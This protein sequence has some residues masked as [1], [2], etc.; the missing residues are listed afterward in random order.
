MVVVVVLLLLLLLLCC[1]PP[2]H[3]DGATRRPFYLAF[4]IPTANLLFV[5]LSLF[6]GLCLANTTTKRTHAA[7]QRARQGWAGTGRDAVFVCAALCSR[8]VV[9]FAPLAT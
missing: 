7:R 6:L 8:V 1:A 9:D 2:H 4:Q 5:F 3:G